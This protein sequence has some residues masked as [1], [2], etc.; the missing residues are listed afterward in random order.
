VEHPCYKCGATIEDGTA[1]CP[2]CAAPQIRVGA[3]LTSQIE[4]PPDLDEQRRHHG[5]QGA[6]DWTQALPAAAVAGLVAAILMLIPL[7]A[8]GLGMLAAGALSVL[9]YQRRNADASLTAGVGARLGALSGM[10]GFAIFAFLTAAETF[11]FHTGGELRTALLEAIKQSAAHSSDPQ[12]KL[13]IEYLQSPPG[14]ILV[15]AAGVI[16]MLFAFL[17]FSCLGGV[18]GAILMR[19]KDKG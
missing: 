6:V 4:L 8:F 11:L 2:Q 18:I 15:M 19:P 12:T 5:A 9:L 7:G 3:G 10:L 16:V 17:I 1:F 14:L 13:V